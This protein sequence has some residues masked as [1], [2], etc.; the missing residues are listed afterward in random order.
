MDNCGEDNDCTVESVTPS[1]K[2]KLKQGRSMKDR[3]LAKVIICVWFIARLPFQVLSASKSPNSCASKK[4][5]LSSTAVEQKRSKVQKLTKE[6]SLEDVSKCGIDIVSNQDSNESI[7]S[8]NVCVVDDEN[9]T[10]EEEKHEQTPKSSSLVEY[11]KK[12]SEAKDSSNTTVSKSKHKNKKGESK[13]HSDKDNKQS[14]SNN[15]NTQSDSNTSVACKSDEIEECE[16]EKNDESTAGDSPRTPKNMKNTPQMRRQKL[17]PKQLAKKQ[18]IEKKREEKEKL[19]MVLRLL[20]LYYKPFQWYYKL[21]NFFTGTRE[22]TSRGKR[23]Q[24]SRKRRETTRE[25]RKTTWKRKEEKGQ[26]TKETNGVR[27]SCI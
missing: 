4:R 11:F 24:T 5:R 26:R 18:E 6:N 2:K 1:K 27:V 9:H 25:R 23:K 21:F 3:I 17:T 19:K 10:K 16:D 7:E 14:D 15:G 13:V 8:V 12:V 20:Y 22:K